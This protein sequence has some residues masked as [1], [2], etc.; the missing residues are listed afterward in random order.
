MIETQ[1]INIKENIIDIRPKYDHDNNSGIFGEIDPYQVIN[2][3]IM[4]E[5]TRSTNDTRV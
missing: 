2:N 3:S 1:I 4:I 5:H